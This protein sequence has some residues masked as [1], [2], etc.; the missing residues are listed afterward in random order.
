MQDFEKRQTIRRMWLE[1]PPDKRTENDLLIFHEWLSE[2][3]PTLLKRGPRSYEQLR[4]D[5]GDLCEE[6]AR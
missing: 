2:N 5:L 3:F 6:L 4:S 1:R